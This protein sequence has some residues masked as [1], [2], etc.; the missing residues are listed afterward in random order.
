[1]QTILT[2]SVESAARKVVE[3]APC[4]EQYRNIYRNTATSGSASGTPFAI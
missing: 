3:A 1:M 2:E 4:A